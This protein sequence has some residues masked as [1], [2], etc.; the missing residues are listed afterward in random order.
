MAELSEEIKTLVTIFRHQT[1]VRRNLSK[2]AKALEARA[3][4][5]DMSKLE[6]DELAGFVEIQQIA[7]NHK[8]DSPEYKASLAARLPEYYPDGIRDMSLLDLIEMVCD[9]EAASK[10]YGKTSLAES[11]P[12]QKERFKVT[13]EQYHLIQLIAEEL[14]K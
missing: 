2:L 7:R 4:I 3:L 6:L 8:I 10:T 1:L 13:D 12:I 9:W 11:L 14:I 5:H